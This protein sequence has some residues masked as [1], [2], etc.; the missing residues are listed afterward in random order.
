[1]KSAS[2]VPADEENVLDPPPCA[3]GVGR[4]R[5]TVDLGHDLA[6]MRESSTIRV[7]G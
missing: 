1:L 5:G 4:R 6:R 7:P 3:F 2:L